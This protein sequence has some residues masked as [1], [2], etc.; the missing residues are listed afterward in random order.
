MRARPGDRD[1]GLL[2]AR[3]RRVVGALARRANLVEKHLHVDAAG[4]GRQQRGDNLAA[5]QLEHLEEDRVPGVVDQLADGGDP[6]VRH[7]E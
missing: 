2:E 5:L 6:V 1:A 4:L 7:G 3:E